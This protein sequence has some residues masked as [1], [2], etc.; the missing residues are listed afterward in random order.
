MS[1]MNPKVCLLGASLGTGNMGV[2][3][4]TV[5]TLKSFYNQ[6]PDGEL[7]II[8]YGKKEV[9]YQYQ[10]GNHAKPVQLFNIRFSKNIFLKN[11]IAF[12][13]AIARLSTCIPF[14][15]IKNK[16]IS[17]NFWLQRITEVDFVAAM[18]GG[19]SFS[20]IY[21][22]RRLLYVSLPQ[23]LALIMG[24][25]LVLLPQ[26]IGPFKNRAA[27]MIARTILRRASAIYSRDREGLQVT[28]DLIGP[29][30][31]ANKIKFCFD[32]GFIV[33]PVKPMVMNL[34]DL[35]DGENRCCYPLIGLNVSGL[36]F[37]G[38][39]TKNNMFG[40]IVDYRNLIYNI[41]EHFITAKGAKILL[42]PHVFG[43]KENSESDSEVCESIYAELKQ[44]HR[45][46]LF[47][48]RGRYDQSEIKYIIGC[49]DF[50]IGS[51]MHACIAALS[52]NIPTVSIAYSRK[53]LGVMQ[54]IGVADLVADPR[55]LN[56]EDIMGLIDQS[57]D[58]RASFK[59]QLEQI[60]PSVKDA[61][62]RLFPDI[63]TGS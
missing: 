42:V 14:R 11:N 28:K 18:S 45:K 26:T 39:Y 21:G 27:K 2:N 9:T 41:I 7:F 33:D 22:M 43:T 59:S 47:M 24:K 51:R 32:V 23:L 3:A 50:F 53:F 35:L 62:L 8:D 5:G 31:S 54:T 63:F 46:S 30:L 52:Q 13:I 25:K 6:Y 49:C 57:Y 40:L 15:S 48:A 58:Q 36:L 10:D 38:G 55:L 19:D 12:L 1:I 34:D 4:L 61:V 17:R 37:M 56:H 44:R 60:M 16:V 20:D 29:S